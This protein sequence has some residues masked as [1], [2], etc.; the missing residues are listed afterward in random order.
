MSHFL[1][2]LFAMWSWNG[3]LSWV[4]QSKN[5]TILFSQTSLEREK[6]LLCYSFQSSKNKNKYCKPNEKCTTH[7]FSGKDFR[8]LQRTKTND[9][10]KNM[11]NNNN[12]KVCSDFQTKNGKHF[13]IRK[14]YFYWECLP[15]LKLLLLDFLWD[16]NFG[17]T[18]HWSWYKRKSLSFPMVL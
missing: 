5:K 16:E 18:L 17:L 4:Y 1:I 10:I 9:S 2:F 3:I 7:F 15:K 6:L 13:Q 14:S 11:S 12:T 8:K